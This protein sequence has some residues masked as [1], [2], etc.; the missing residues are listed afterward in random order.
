[1]TFVFL[2][3]SPFAKLV[4]KE[5]LR[6]NLQPAAVFSP[7]D[8]LNEIKKIKPDLA[9]VVAFGKIIKQDLLNVCPFINLHPSLLP[10]Y[11]GP[12]PLQTAILNQDKETG[13]TLML[14]DERVDS[15][16]ILKQEKILINPQWNWQ[17]LG[18]FAFKRGGELLV[19]VLNNFKKIKSIPQDKSQA[20]YTKLIKR[21]DGLLKP[22]DNL[23]IK[24]R[25][26]YHWP[27]VYTFWQNKRLKIIDEKTVQLEGK[28]AMSIANF[29]RG[30]QQAEKLFRELSLLH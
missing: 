14:L 22:G 21:E 9:V 17:E 11:R 10:K 16:P 3:T 8:D 19:N 27:G 29:L 12:S 5:L 4:L 2:G 7:D 25:A 18:D 30:H 6:N 20:T 15:G 24:L 26:F 23:K 1:M 28:K 13:I